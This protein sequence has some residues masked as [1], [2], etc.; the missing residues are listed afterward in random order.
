MKTLKWIPLLILLL[1]GG[2]LAQGGAAARQ[3]VESSMVVTGHASVRGDGSVS[4][5]E[6]DQPEKLPPVALE[7]VARVAPTWRFEP[8]SMDGGHGVAKV[9]MRLRL[10]ANRLGDGTYRV[11]IRNGYFGKDLPADDERV[12]PDETS[13]LRI[14]SQPAISYPDN[15]VNMRAQ[16]RVYLIMKLGRDG[17]VQDVVAEQ[18]NLTIVGTA[19]QMKTARDLLAVAAIRG[20]RRWTYQ[21]PTTGELARKDSWS[22]RVTVDFIRTMAPQPEEYGRWNA[23][24]PGPRQK[25]PWLED[26]LGEYG[27][28]DLVDADGVQLAE[29]GLRL[30]TPLQ[31]G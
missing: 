15:A 14:V 31:S 21:P 26:D 5:W 19:Q 3:Q 8:V 11:V 4:E 25:A 24:I 10:V 1:S 7:L 29:R 20:A 6:L 16:G 17:R 18:V 13:V 9:P 2:A 30:L 23:Y 28:P 12:Q 27:S 22:V